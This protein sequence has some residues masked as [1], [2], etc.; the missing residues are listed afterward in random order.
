[1]PLVTIDA[2][3]WGVIA[4]FALIFGVPYSRYFLRRL[5]IPTWPVTEATVVAASARRGSPIASGMG[6]P[7]LNYC[8]A[9]Y[10]YQVDGVLQKGSL[11]L[12]A[13]NET[14][15]TTIAQQIVQMKI[16]VRFNPKHPVDSIPVPE[17]IL[18]RRVVLKDSWLNPR[19][20]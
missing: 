5:A 6:S 3:G 12:M 10:E 4:L 14:I 18:E 7:L 1:M 11:A 2:F 20:W 17:E 15:A 13:G 16:L 19:V 8:S 9:D